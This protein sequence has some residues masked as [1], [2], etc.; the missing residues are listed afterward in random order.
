MVIDEVKWY[1]GLCVTDNNKALERCFLT[2]D[3]V[4]NQTFFHYTTFNEPE[5]IFIEKITDEVY[6]SYGHK[7]NEEYCSILNLSLKYNVPITLK[8]G[9]YI[10]D[11]EE[12][13]ITKNNKNYILTPGNL[14][15][16]KKVNPSEEIVRNIISS[17]TS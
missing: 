10:V 13:L 7:G 6:V 14:K 9:N 3:D 16:K 12:T 4:V 5:N 17:E 2:S 8:E 1:N 15:K 11:V